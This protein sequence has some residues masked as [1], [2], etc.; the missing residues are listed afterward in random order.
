MYRIGELA[1]TTNLSKRTIDYYTQIGL[2]NPVRADSNY[3]LYSDE[4][5]QIL[6]L[7]EHYKNLNMPLEEIK[8]A[9]ELMKANDEI[10]KEKVEKHVDQIAAIMAH[11]KEEIKL[12]E[13]FL[14]KLNSNEKEM[15][16]SKLSPQGITLAQTLLLLLN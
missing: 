4:C 12:M 15:V 1:K 3:R 10:D 7:V 11:L 9:I 5:I 16:V 8:G 6:E 13:P 14:E 2:L